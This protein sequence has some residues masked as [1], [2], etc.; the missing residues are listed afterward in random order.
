VV[1]LSFTELL[2]MVVVLSELLPVS[3]VLVLVDEL[4]AVTT[5]LVVLLDLMYCVEVLV[6]S[7][8]LDVLAVSTVLVL[9][10]VVSLSDDSHKSPSIASRTTNDPL[11][12]ASM[13]FVDESQM[14]ASRS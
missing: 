3:M 6:D 1:L 4:L 5:V 9:D 7:V 8:L 13:A 11:V 12:T 14:H 10:V 2:L